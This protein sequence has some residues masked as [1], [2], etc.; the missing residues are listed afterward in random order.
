MQSKTKTARLVNILDDEAACYRRLEAVLADEETAMSLSGKNRFDGIQR[1]KQALVT[2]IQ[3]VENARQR[4]VD[5]LADDL[6]MTQSPVT[7][8]D[9]APYLSAS[10][11]NDLLSSAER[12]RSVLFDVRV[13]N[14]RNQQLIGQYQTLINGSLKL[15]TGLMDDPPVYRKPGSSAQPSGYR[16][17]CGR[18]FCGTG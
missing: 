14:E 13:K 17:G 9:L 15:L 1:D 11:G 18:I 10:E 3:Q 8:G 7:V 12:L 6:G 5:R 16:S 2:K 4:L